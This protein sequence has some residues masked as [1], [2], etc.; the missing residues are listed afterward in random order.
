ML[1]GDT[2]K[3]KCNGEISKGEINNIEHQTQPKR[4]VNP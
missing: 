1:V 4:D 2:K 3:K